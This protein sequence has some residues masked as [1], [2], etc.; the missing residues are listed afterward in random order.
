MI[1]PARE[2]VNAYTHLGGAI[3]ALIGLVWML[4]VTYPDIPLMLV[5]LIY[6]I[7]MIFCLA[8]SGLMHSYSGD[9]KFLRFL[10]RLDHAAIYCMIAGTYTPFVYTYFDG[11]ARVMLLI[12]IWSMAVGGMYWK[13]QHWQTD[14]LLSVMLYLLMGWAAVL[15]APYVI[16]KMPITVGVLVVAGGLVFSMGA[17]VFHL[18][19]P[20]FNRWW[21]FHEL[22]HLFVLGGCGL[23]FWAIVMILA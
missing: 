6:G 22:W 7:S 21:G 23:H 11:I 5:S 15:M 9:R 2:P 4:A 8:S 14:S 17:L 10:I 19:R 20:N 12:I 16:Q 13:L 3:L 18:R 1:I